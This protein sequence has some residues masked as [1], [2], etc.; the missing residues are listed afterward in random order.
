MTTT[1]TS[2]L[3]R[4]LLTLAL[5]FTLPA[6]AACGGEATDDMEGT[7][8]ATAPAEEVMEEPME[9]AMMK[10]AAEGTVVAAEM[11]DGVQVAEI[12]AG[13]MGYDPG[14]VSLQAGVPARLTFTRTVD[15][16]C[17]SQVQIPAFG[18]PVTD[19]PMN[20]PVTVEFTPEEGGEYA[21]VCGMDMQR[22]M[23][24]VRT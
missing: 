11:V 2:D 24:V 21:F 6:L 22:G 15:S 23:L 20:E 3:F 16:E 18:V 17:S 13:R 19:L 1:Q 7:T 5:L 8:Q 14:A 10:E 9:D 12:E 4:R